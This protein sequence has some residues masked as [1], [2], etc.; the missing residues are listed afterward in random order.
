MDCPFTED[1]RW[2]LEL[3]RVSEFARMDRLPK[4]GLQEEEVS[5]TNVQ[6]VAQQ[7]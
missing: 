5:K 1:A 2:S 4:K 3:G 6:K 7:W